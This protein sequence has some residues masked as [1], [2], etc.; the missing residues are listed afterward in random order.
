MLLF[1]DYVERQATTIKALTVIREGEP[2]HEHIFHSR[3]STSP[4]DAESKTDSRQKCLSLPWGMFSSV[5]CELSSLLLKTVLEQ[6]AW[7]HVAGNIL[8]L[9]HFDI[10]YSFYEQILCGSYMLTA[11]CVRPFL[12]RAHRS[13]LVLSFHTQ[14]NDLMLVW[15]GSWL[16]SFSKSMRKVVKHLGYFKETNNLLLLVFTSLKL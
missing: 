2:G 1:R 4:I 16:F 3:I 15:C 13:C 12:H 8:H 14:K 6:P 7:R 11:T 10:Y 5:R 9:N